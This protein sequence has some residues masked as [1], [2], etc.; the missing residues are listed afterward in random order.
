MTSFMSRFSKCLSVVA[1]ILASFLILFLGC[2]KKEEGVLKIGA[3]LPLSGDAAVWGNNTKDGIDLAVE[4][5]N[6]IGGIKGRTVKVIYEDTEA[7]PAKGV[8]AYKKLTSIDKVEVIIDNSVSSV[9]LAMAPMAEKD[10]VVI[11]ATGAT[12]PKISEAGEFIF[13]IWN[14]D[15]YEGE[16]SA[17]FAIND[18]GL[19]KV[20]IL[21]INNDYGIG[22]EKVF[23]SKFNEFGGEV[24]ESQS[25][26][27][28]ATDMRT[29]LT[30]ISAST[31]DVLYLVG[32]PKEIPIAL[33][34][35]KELGINMPL[36]GTVAMED[37]QLI[38]SAGNAAEGLMYPFPVA[39]SGE[40]VNQFR[41]SFMN[42]YG[43]EPGITC[44]VG[45]DAVNMIAKSILLSGGDR[46]EEIRKGLN[47]IEDYPGVSGIMTFD[48]NGD[49]QKPMMMK[50]IKNG[51][52]NWLN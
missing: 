10:S 36:I 32:Y 28:S 45:Y 39:P 40:H 43:K 41:N 26:D 25:F 22:L 3:T 8:N 52:F 21:Y 31:P 46:G 30:K 18:L 20:A 13:R 42:K 4:E 19:K 5:L 9:T 37:P 7:L 29:Q 14:S 49:V 44:D 1:I 6:A 2:G 27:Q 35:I 38:Q 50:V 33:R 24:V 15:A 51:A 17:S 23:N 47:M 12:A 34:Q 11:L 48:E 16:F